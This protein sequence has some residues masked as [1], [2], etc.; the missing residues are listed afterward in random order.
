LK[1]PLLPSFWPLGRFCRKTLVLQFCLGKTLVLQFCLG[2]I[3]KLVSFSFRVANH[4]KVVLCLLSTFF[5][6]IRILFPKISTLFGS[7]L[8]LTQTSDILFW[9]LHLLYNVVSYLPNCIYLLC[10]PFKS[11]S[12]A[13]TNSNYLFT[14]FSSVEIKLNS[15]SFS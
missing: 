9:P 12:I 1:W 15:C 13:D 6:P 2:K 10:I 7:F 11:T 3:N 5:R 4:R 14:G 8:L